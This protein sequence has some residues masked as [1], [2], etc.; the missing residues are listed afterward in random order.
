M[1]KDVKKTAKGGAEKSVEA[2]PLA[3]IK[4]I[5]DDI[6]EIASMR[7][8][9]EMAIRREESS[10]QFYMIAHSRAC[11]RV[12]K[13]LFLRLAQE[14]LLHKQNLQRQLDEVE[15]RI[16]TDAAMSGGEIS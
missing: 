7:D 13:E 16:L 14:E 5:S 12:D 4:S 9:L 3:G 10:H 1:K 11:H 8:I 15:A 2:V 6:D